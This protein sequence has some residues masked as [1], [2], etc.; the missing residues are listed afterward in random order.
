MFNSLRE[1]GNSSLGN[2]PSLGQS[3][4]FSFGQVTNTSDFR[5]EGNMTLKDSSY[6]Y[7]K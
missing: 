1:E 7:I 2:K 6:V 4:N 3:S 5:K